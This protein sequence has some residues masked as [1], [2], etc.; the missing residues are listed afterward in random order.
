MK[1]PPNAPF[2][3]WISRSFFT[4]VDGAT[5]PARISDCCA[6]GLSIRYTRGLGGAFTVAMF[7]FGSGVAGAFQS[8]NTAS[9]CGMIASSVVSP[10]I[11]NFALSGRR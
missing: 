11:R 1:L 7:F 8:P 9:S 10:A 2:I 6:P 5:T 4:F 3:V